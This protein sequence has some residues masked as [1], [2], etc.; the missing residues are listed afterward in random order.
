MNVI[1]AYCIL[2]SRDQGVVCGVVESIT[3]MPGGLACA[4]VREASQIHG[5]SGGVN[6]L[7]E[8]AN[9]GLGNAR[10]SEPAVNPITIYGVC[11]VLPCTPK[12]EKNLR[13]AR[14]NKAFVGSE[15][16]R[17]ATKTVVS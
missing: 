7:F 5:W 13:Q 1:D 15:S 9:H 6:T 12:A 10:I 4:V 16:P 2:R 14:W 8:A 11:G 17:R 3:A